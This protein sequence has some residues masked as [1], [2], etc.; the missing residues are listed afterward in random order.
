MHTAMADLSLD[1]LNVVYPGKADYRLLENVHVRGFQ[2][3]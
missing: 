1:E 3:C 2:L